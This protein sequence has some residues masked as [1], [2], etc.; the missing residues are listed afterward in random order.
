MINNEKSF[1]TIMALSAPKFIKDSYYIIASSYYF[2]SIKM[3]NLLTGDTLVKRLDMV[4]DS[5]I[6]ILIISKDY[7]ELKVEKIGYFF[8]KDFILYY[9]PM[10][11]FFSKEIIK[12]II[13]ENKNI[14]QFIFIFKDKDYGNLV[15]DF[16]LFN[17]IISGGSNTKKH[18]LSPIQLRL[19]RFLIAY[20]PLTG[21]NVSNSFHSKR[22]KKQAEFDFTS[23]A[24]K[25]EKAKYLANLKEEKEREDSIPGPRG[26]K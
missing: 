14:H 22:E 21:F 13:F 26:E 9:V 2:G 4:Y 3:V 6:R 18:I 10:D 15:A 23:E 25:E 1:Y 17:I 5:N 24:I 20:L 19:A 16:N 12:E 8:S 7:K 11:L